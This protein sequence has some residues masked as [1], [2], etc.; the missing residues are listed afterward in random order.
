LV[1]LPGKRSISSLFK[2]L[3]LG[4]PRSDGAGE[5]HKRKRSIEKFTKDDEV[6]L[7]LLSTKAG[8]FDINLTVADTVII[9]DSDW[10][11]QND[12]QAQS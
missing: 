11:P 4:P 9:C 2:D 7:F 8:G 12:I 10:N 5:I 3:R 6:F 1:I